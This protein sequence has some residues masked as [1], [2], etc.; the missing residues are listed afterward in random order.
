MKTIRWFEVNIPLTAR[1]FSKKL[2]EYPFSKDSEEGFLVKKVSSFEVVGQ[3]IQS[4]TFIKEV[5][6]PFGDINTISGVDYNTIDFKFTIG[7][8]SLLEV[9][10]KPRTL[11]PF[12]NEL[13]R[14][15]GFGFFIANIN[16]NL[17]D[18]IPL[19]ESQFGK[20][21]ITKM[22]ISDLNV[23]NIA[24]GQLV[25]TSDRDVR[26]SLDSY[27]FRN[28]DYKVKS[29]K[30]HL[31]HSNIYQGSFEVN[32]NSR[33]ELSYMPNQAFIKEYLPVFLKSIN[34]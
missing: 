5:K 18:F 21:I 3:Y 26:E 19:V 1:D 2:L 9:Y 12:S 22:E 13:S 29:I 7:E 32:R 17:S 23:D 25:L 15:I 30:A 4:K 11:Q 14:I 27:I 28:K 24:L 16:I 6:T 8:K 34:D 33:L 10:S 31:P 20:L